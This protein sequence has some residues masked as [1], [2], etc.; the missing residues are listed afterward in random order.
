MANSKF[1][2]F[3]KQNKVKKENGFY[4][5]TKSLCD[6]NG[7]PLK[8]EFKHITPKENDVIREEC[9]K[10]IPVAGKSGMYRTKVDAGKYVRKLIAA[11][12][13]FPDLYDA[14]LMDSY[15]VNKPEDLL[16]ELVDDVGEYN[17]LAEFVQKFQGFTSSF[18]D[19]VDEA[20]N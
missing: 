6:E 20:K 11:S 1:A 5:P 19:K 18:E 14:E 9:S 13:V 2:A 3:M 4:A 7:A 16:V 12:V 8:W 17:D 10:E 15:G